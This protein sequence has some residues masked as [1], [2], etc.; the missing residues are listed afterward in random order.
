M[1][2]Q[3]HC[4]TAHRSHAELRQHIL[5]LL[6]RGKEKFD[7]Q[8]TKHSAEKNAESNLKLPSGE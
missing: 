2:H 1:S 8:K 7:T 4:T 6:T 3:M 5:P